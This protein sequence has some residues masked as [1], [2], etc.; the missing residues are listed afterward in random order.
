MDITDKHYIAG[1]FDGEGCISIANTSKVL[2]W[3]KFTR[4]REPMFTSG[5]SQAC[6]QISSL[7]GY[8]PI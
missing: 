2:G 3:A 5:N 4:I 1:F 8:L 6:R 7:K